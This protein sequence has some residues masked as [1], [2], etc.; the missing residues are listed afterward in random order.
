MVYQGYKIPAVYDSLLVK[1]TVYG[2]TWNEAT[3]RLSRAL[4]NFVIVGPKTTIPFYRRLLEEEEFMSGRFDTEYLER[5]PELFEYRLMEREE[6]KLARLLAEV[7]H[8]KYN[9]FAF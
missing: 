5:H 7:H 9:P 1:L 8:R 3:S 6:A 2:F 4:N